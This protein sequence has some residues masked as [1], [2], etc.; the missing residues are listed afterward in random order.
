MH[1]EVDVANPTLEI[2][3]GMF[4]NASIVLNQAKDVLVAP[5]GALDR[6]EKGARVLLVDAA[7]RV[8]PR[9]VVLGIEMADRVEIQTGLK[10]SDLVVVGN[11]AQ[12]TAGAT[13]TPKI[14]ETETTQ[15]SR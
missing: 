14:A 12:L 13:V 11:R 10:A 9:D 2:V 15:E 3:P 7:G 1:V 8:E 6:T 4:A 5:V